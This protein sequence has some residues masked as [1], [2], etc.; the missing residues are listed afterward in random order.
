MTNQSLLNSDL[1][2]CFNYNRFWRSCLILTK[3][4]MLLMLGRYNTSF[5]SL[6]LKEAGVLWR[7]PW[8]HKLVPYLGVNFGTFPIEHKHTY[9]VILSNK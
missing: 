6:R 7:F 3:Y 1:F 2:I 8:D 9:N 4:I 5:L